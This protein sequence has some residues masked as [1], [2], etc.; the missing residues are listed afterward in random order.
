MGGTTPG[1]RNVIANSAG[2]TLTGATG[3]T[4]A[5][6]QPEQI[7]KFREAQPAADQYSTAATLYTL[8]TG[9]HLFDVPEEAHP[10]VLFVKILQE[11]PVPIRSR[12]PEIAEGLAAIIHRALAKESKD[13][14]PDVKAMRQAL[15]PF[16]T[17]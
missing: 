10:M 17:N 1:A 8:L 3:G 12:R 4:A 2:L 11:A 9:K 16:C 7:D 5:F 6:M 15:L 14:F 13:R